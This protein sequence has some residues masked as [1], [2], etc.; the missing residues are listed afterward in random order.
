MIGLYLGSVSGMDATLADTNMVLAAP[1][2]IRAETWSFVH[3]DEGSQFA[4]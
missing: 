4:L 1:G 2:I 3:I